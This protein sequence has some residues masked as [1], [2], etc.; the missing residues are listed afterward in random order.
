[1]Q[2]QEYLNQISA[3]NRPEQKSKLGGILSSKFFLIGAGLVAALIVII[4]IGMALSGNKGGEEDNCYKLYL[5]LESTAEV[6]GEYQDSVK[7]STL[8]ASGA[9]LRGVLENTKKDLESYLTEKYD[10][11]PKKISEDLTLEMTTEKD[12][13]MSE[14]FEAKINGNLD[15]IFA[16][17]MAK[18]IALIASE[19][20]KISKST[21]ND[22]LKGLLKTSYDSL[23]SLYN[24]FN[25]FSETK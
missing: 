17:K 6:I 21:K 10:F 2:G 24:N 1:M 11:T 8:R 18:E 20:A 23:D 16:H 4:V 3:S 9:S 19:E 25:D 12:E 7:S 15:R 14:L 22:T 13:L 5:H